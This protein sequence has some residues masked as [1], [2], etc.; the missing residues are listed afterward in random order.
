MSLTQRWSSENAWRWH[1]K[2]PWLCGF[3]YVPGSAVN[4]TEFW[5]AET[6][7]LPTIEREMG[8][9][10]E[11]GMNTCRVF[12]PFLVWDHDPEGMLHR[13]EKFL[14][15]ASHY[16]ISTLLTLFDDCAFANKQPYLGK[17]DEPVP[18]VHNSGWTPSPGQDR[19][20]NRAAW[21]RLEEYVQ[22]VIGC[23]A[24]DTRVAA[25]DLYNEP[26]NSGMGNQSLPLLEQSFL[27]AQAVRPDQ[28]ITAGIWNH[29]LIELNACLLD[30]SDI[31]SFH[32]YGNLDR[33]QKE[34]ESLKKHG[35]PL[36]C[37]EWMARTLGSRWEVDLPYLK[38]ERV[39]CYSWGLVSGR[40]QTKYPW[41]TPQG[42]PEPEVWF[43]DLFHPDGRAYREEEIAAIRRQ[44]KEERSHAG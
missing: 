9:A 12:L 43:H 8:W 35:Y 10:A 28:P 3:N 30:Q 19:V 39:G 37:T 6:F 7:D 21:P 22:E 42:A 5:Q 13:L 24:H 26:G 33:M 2:T 1:Q 25:W 4:T 29:E 34:V 11:I 31:I 32:C 20:V 17:Q 15:T 44:T 27:W 18:S 41:G 36:L 23:F 40:T 14:A 16:R 38:Q